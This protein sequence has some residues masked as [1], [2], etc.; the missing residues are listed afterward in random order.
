MMLGI[1]HR[2]VSSS[3][4]HVPCGDGHRFAAS[5]S[6]L[7]AHPPAHFAK[8]CGSPIPRVSL[9]GFATTFAALAIVPPDTPPLD[10]PACPLATSISAAPPRFIVASLANAVPRSHGTLSYPTHDT[11]A[12]PV[13]FAL[14]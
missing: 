3:N 1:V 7:S 14:S 2:F 8:K 12:H 13:A 10:R 4:A 5:T 9:F 6:G 11:S